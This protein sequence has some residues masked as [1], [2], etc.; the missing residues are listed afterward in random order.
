MPRIDIVDQTW[1]AV[2]PRVAADLVSRDQRWRGW[3]PDVDLQVSERRGVQGMRWAV[4]RV[5]RGP[6]ATG[7]MEIWLQPADDGVVLHYFLRLDLPGGRP[8]R[9][10][11]AGERHR[12]HGRRTAWQIKDELEAAHADQPRR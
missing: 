12:R 2:P 10:R 1:I 3:W 8:R 9:A 7:T 5:R 6:A 4:R 11:R